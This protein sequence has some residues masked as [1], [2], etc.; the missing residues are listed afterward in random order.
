[1][2][3]NTHVCM[4]IYLLLGEQHTNA[5]WYMCVH[6][7]MYIH[8]YI[9]VRRAIFHGS[10]LPPTLFVYNGDLSGSYFRRDYNNK[11]IVS[12]RLKLTINILFLRA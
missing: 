4:Y 7:Y 1:M 2:I 6:I 10:N 9:V 5:C 11:Y 3:H 12:V 8:V